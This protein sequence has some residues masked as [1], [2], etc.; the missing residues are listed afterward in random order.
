MLAWDDHMMVSA[1]GSLALACS[2]A[3]LLGACMPRQEGCH[4]S[5]A[6]RALPTTSLG[7]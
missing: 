1:H 5:W 4:G 7:L 3:S 6:E 2:L